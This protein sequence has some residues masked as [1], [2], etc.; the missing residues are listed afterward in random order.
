MMKFV[1]WIL[2][3]SAVGIAIGAS[4]AAVIIGVV[5]SNPN[6]GNL[7]ILA[8]SFLTATIFALVAIAFAIA[9]RET[10]K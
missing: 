4:M 10:K 1:S 6:W 9:D 5:H 2:G 7:L 8:A 3:C